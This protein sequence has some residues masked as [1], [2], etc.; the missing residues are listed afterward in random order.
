MGTTMA[1]APPMLGGDV[2][3]AK[4]HFDKALA[5]GKRKFFMAQYYYARYYAPREQDKTLFFELLKEVTEGDP[6]GL[7]DVCL[8]NTVIKSRADQLQEMSDELF[9]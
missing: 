3:G 5:L 8:I 6:E 9:F 7:R 4:L 1:A 2:Q